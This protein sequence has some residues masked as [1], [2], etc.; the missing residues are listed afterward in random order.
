[1]LF[2]ILC[3]FYDI[4]CDELALLTSMVSMANIMKQCCLETLETAGTAKVGGAS[5]Q[6][7][8]YRSQILGSLA[9]HPSSVP[10]LQRVSM[11]QKS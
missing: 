4:L 3:T 10:G 5:V 7:L 8:I 6:F 11:V 2:L 9:T 1:M